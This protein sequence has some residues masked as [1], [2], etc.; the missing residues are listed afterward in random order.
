MNIS[1]L[2]TENSINYHVSLLYPLYTVYCGYSTVTYY[3][4][5]VIK[6]FPLVENDD[7]ELFLLF[8]KQHA[9]MPS[10]YIL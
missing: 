10:S 7:D 6:K 2:H 8:H 3:P 1:V 9:Q 4:T 5:S